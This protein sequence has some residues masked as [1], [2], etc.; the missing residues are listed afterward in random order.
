MRSDKAMSAA[1]PRKLDANGLLRENEVHIDRNHDIRSQ[2]GMETYLLDLTNSASFR[3][4]HHG[5]GLPSYCDRSG[6]FL[7]AQ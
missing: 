1:P 3:L 5:V 7:A 2:I 4:C 6:R